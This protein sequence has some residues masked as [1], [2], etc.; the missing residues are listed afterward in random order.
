M[1]YIYDVEYLLASF[2]TVAESLTALVCNVLPIL[3]L[4][5][6]TW[7]E[8]RTHT[9]TEYASLEPLLKVLLLRSDTA[10]NHDL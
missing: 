5:L 4:H 9:Y 8:L 6:I 10:S 3:S 2:C 7:E 1:G